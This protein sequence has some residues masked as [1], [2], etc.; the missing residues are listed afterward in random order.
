MHDHCKEILQPLT[1]KEDKFAVLNYSNPYICVKD[2]D[3][4]PPCTLH[5]ELSKLGFKIISL[6]EKGN[7][8]RKTHTL[9][10]LIV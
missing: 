8:S 9:I 6:T 5:K 7:Y 1:I 10:K 2:K 3:K 4:L